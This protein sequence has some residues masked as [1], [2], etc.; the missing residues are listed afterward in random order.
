MLN[1]CNVMEARASEG[2]RQ[3][4]SALFSESH[5]YGTEEQEGEWTERRIPA[6]LTSFLSDES[7]VER[8]KNGIA[9]L[10]RAWH[11]SPEGIC[12]SAL[13]HTWKF[14]SSD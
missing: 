2:E 14:N 6:H 7:C 9:Q 5:A 13:I 10:L 11:E 3:K 12:K 1:G 8:K 4:K